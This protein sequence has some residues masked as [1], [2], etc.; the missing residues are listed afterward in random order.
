LAFRAGYYYDPSPA[1]KETHNVLV[2]NYDFNCFA[3]GFGYAQ[4]GFHIDFF[5]ELLK[6]KERVVS[7]ADTMK[8]EGSKA[9]PGTYNLTLYVPGVSIGYSW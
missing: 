9:M 5:F 3:F 2:P 8:I 7:E 6:A 1:P 4:N